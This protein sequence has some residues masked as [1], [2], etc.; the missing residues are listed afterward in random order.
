MDC[1]ACHRGLTLK[2]DRSTRACYD[3]HRGDDVHRGEFGR[4][5]ERCHVTSTFGAVRVR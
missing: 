2:M 5:C 3:C 1:H 4:V